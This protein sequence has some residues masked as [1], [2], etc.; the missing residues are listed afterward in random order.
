MRLLDDLTST[1]NKGAAAAERG[2]KTVK[3]K[4]QVSDLN[5]KRQQLSAQLGASLYE[6]TKEDPSFRDGRES[7]Y[8]EIAACDAERDECMRLI[9]EIEQQAA[10][11]ATASAV[12]TCNVCGSAV[13]GNDLFCS[14]CGNSIEQIKNAAAI[15]SLTVATEQQATAFCASCGS[16]MSPSDAFCMECG[17]KAGEVAEEPSKEEPM[18]EGDEPAAAEASPEPHSA[19]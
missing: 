12:Y 11:Q 4:A 13:G 5:K 8:D 1:L 7:L 18:E 9:E 3:L 19:E 15:T 14:G 16:P 6:A 2:A 10:Q 17:A